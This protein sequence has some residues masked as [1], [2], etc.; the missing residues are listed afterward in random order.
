MK[1][2]TLKHFD[3]YKYIDGGVCAA[4]GFK[5]NGLYSGIKAAMDAAM[6]PDGNES[7]HG[8]G[9]FDL[10]LVASDVMCTAAAVFTQN[11]VKGAPVTLSQKHLKATGGR[12]QGF[13][14]NSKNANTCNFDGEQKAQRMC[15]LAAGKLENQQR[16]DR[17]QNGKHHFHADCIADPFLVAFPGK[18]GSEDADPGK[19]SEDHQIIDENQLIHDGNP[20][21]LA[22]AD[23]T[24]HDVVEHTDE[25]RDS[26]LDHDRNC[27][28][29]RMPIE[30]LRSEIAVFL[31]HVPLLPMH[32]SSLGSGR[33]TADISISD[34]CSL[35][36]CRMIY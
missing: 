2:I 25:V 19:T 3:G 17:K 27:N 13:I 16:Q 23:L 21:H 1:E 22:R 28:L 12:A 29:Q 36:N 10:C 32:L 11:K 4:K 6:K 14:L 35:R 24:D 7:P 18:L 26:I 31:K 8:E 20:G 33:C 9:K 34:F 30:F 5:A 15:E